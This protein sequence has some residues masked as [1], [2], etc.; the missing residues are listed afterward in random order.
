MKVGQ[1]KIAHIM[2]QGVPL[3]SPGTPDA[4]ATA[5]TGDQHHKQE[6]YNSNDD[7]YSQGINC[8]KRQTMMHESTIHVG[9]TSSTRQGLNSI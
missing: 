7:D 3:S 4:A 5:D 9:S 8:T 1:Y 2:C 6:A